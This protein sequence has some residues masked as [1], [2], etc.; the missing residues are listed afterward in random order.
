MQ[1][2]VSL[3][4]EILEYTVQLQFPAT[5]NEREYKTLITG[6]KLAKSIEINNLIVHSDSHHVMW[7][8]NGEYDEAI[9]EWMK[10]YVNI[11]H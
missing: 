3:E 2:L 1:N 4:N 9:E 7:Q 10:I 5:N 6:L 8:V 11:I